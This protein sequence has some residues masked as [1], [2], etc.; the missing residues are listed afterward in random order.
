MRRDKKGGIGLISKLILAGNIL[1]VISLL[2]AYLAPVTD[3]NSFW[4]VA[5]FGLAYPFILLINALFIIYWLIRKPVF[6]LISLIPILIGYKSVSSYIGFREITAIEVPKSSKNFIRVMTYNVHFFKKF[7]DTNDD[8]TKD[9]MLNIIRKEQPDVICFQEFFSRQKGDYNF[10]KLIQE[11]LNTENFYF[12]PNIDN[13]Y[14]AMGMAV[15]SKLPIKA[16]GS[17]RFDSVTRGNEAIYT[18]VEFQKKLFRIYNVHFQSINFQPEDY[19]DFKKATKKINPDVESSRRI[20]GRLKNAFQKRADQIKIIKS[21]SRDC[22]YPYVIAGDFN[23]TPI[24]YA[25]SYMSKGLKNTFVEKGSGF[26]ITYNGLFPNFQIDYI[27]TSPDFSVKNYR[28]IKKKL[29]DHYA[30]RSDLEYAP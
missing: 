15:F 2:L 24:S 27:L 6:S 12:V 17:I 18:D 5:F 9:E 28:I 11:V 3:P 8:F 20:G 30:V 21:H 25:V 14:E 4:L 16:K 29:S 26:G 22:K 7:G 1:A 23:D 19:S 13:N 10:K